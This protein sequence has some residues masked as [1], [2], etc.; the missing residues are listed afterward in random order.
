MYGLLL[1]I[2]AMLEIRREIALLAVILV[3]TYTAEG[4]WLGIALVTGA[5]LLAARIPFLREPS[6]SPTTV[7][8]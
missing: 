4:M 6:S 7:S 8:A 3:A 5:N 1:T 2:P